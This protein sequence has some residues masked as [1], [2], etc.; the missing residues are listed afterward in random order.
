MKNESIR[1]GV[2]MDRLLWHEKF[3]RALAQKVE[4]GYPIR[5]DIINLNK[6]DWLNIVEPYDVIIWTGDETNPK[7]ADIY[8]KKMFFLEKFLNKL[9][10]PN[11]QTTWHFESK[12]AQSYIFSHYKIHTPKTTVAFE[13]NN[14]CDQ[15]RQANMPL[16]FKKSYGAGSKNV[17]LIKKHTEAL[18]IIDNIFNQT[19]WDES[20]LQYKS[21][22]PWL[23][24]SIT[25]QWFWHHIY[26]KI[27]NI[28]SDRVVYW[29]EFIPN[30]EADLR[31][32]V[33]GDCYMYGWWRKNRPGDF[34][35]SGSGRPDYDRE[36]PLEPLKYCLNMNR[37]FSFD[38]MA[39]DILFLNHEFLV[40]E[41]SFGYMDTYLYNIDGHYITDES[42]GLLF[43]K[44]HTWP[45]ELWIDWTLRK[46]RRC[47]RYAAIINKTTINE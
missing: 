36:I 8:N 30:N 13:H 15:V 35:A 20:K 28:E 4:Q 44:G 27:F 10:I 19:L 33:I 38:S 37:Q 31:I 22:I 40:S 21:K 34:T 2:G 3:C 29:Q 1:I 9:V 7:S 47:Q 43:K 32:T 18:S 17:R 11:Y 46:L 14:A 23:L 39:Y 45:Q 41:M 16:V 26:Q 6:H 25:Q 42:G 24:R 5:Y 12:I